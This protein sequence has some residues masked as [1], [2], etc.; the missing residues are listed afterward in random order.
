VAD[1]TTYA[2]AFE[3]AAGVKGVPQEVVEHLR[4]GAAGERP[5][6]IKPGDPR[7]NHAQFE[8]VGSRAIALA[9]ASRCAEGLG[10]DVRVESAPTSG[11]ARE[12]GQAFLAR[13]R[14]AAA[15]GARPLCVLAAGETTV[16]VSGDGIGGRNQEFA[17]AAAPGLG[18]LGRAS[19]LASA[20]TDG[21]DGPTDAAGG[22]V[23]SSTL[24]RALR[25]GLDLSSSLERN[26][27][28]HFFAPLG[29]LIA[30]G[31]TGT[32]VGDVHVLLV[33]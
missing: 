14:K 22:L 31:P 8:I 21:I 18:A 20:G 17:L 25:L 32:N 23:D 30:W 28:Y 4:R 27:A 9:A 5:E 29:D 33:A 13:A 6:S 7:L 26:D 12:A 2:Q 19:L 10:Y 16:T 3:I 11:E 15:S 1:P 24:D